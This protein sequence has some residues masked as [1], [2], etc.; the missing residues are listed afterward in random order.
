MSHIGTFEAL[1]VSHPFL[2]T[3]ALA[4]I[5]LFFLQGAIS[6]MV[7]L[8]LASKASERDLDHILTLLL[9][10]ELVGLVLLV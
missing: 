4:H 8:I 1:D 10:L 5:H 9:V 7:T 3:F 6:R 2:L